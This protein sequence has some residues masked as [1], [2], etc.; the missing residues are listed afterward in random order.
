[1]R[2]RGHY[3]YVCICG[4]GIGWHNSKCAKNVHT[5]C[6][7]DEIDYQGLVL[8]DRKCKCQFFALNN[9][10]Y[11]EILNQRKEEE[12]KRQ[13]QREQRQRHLATCWKCRWKD[14]ISY[15]FS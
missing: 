4:H 6:N 15:L 7:W 10:E 1:M 13:E 5:Y 3:S 2:G 12:R 8:G 9:L 11:L 14:K